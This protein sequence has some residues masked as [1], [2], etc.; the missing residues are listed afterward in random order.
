MFQS[1]EFVFF[2]LAEFCLYCFVFTFF[3]CPNNL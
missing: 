2:L 1:H 3:F